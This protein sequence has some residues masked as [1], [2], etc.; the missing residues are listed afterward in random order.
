[1]FA[2]V[3]AFV[4]LI[5]MKKTHAPASCMSLV[6]VINTFGL[7][8]MIVDCAPPGPIRTCSTINKF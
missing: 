6:S 2:K 1:M 5:L 3:K 4:G 7:V 8:L